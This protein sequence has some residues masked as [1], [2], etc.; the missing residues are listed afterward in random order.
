MDRLIESER[1]ILRTLKVEDAEK[2]FKWL[3]DPRVSKFMPY[4]TYE[5]VGE[6]EEWIRSNLNKEREFYFSISLKETGE[7][8]G[9]AS[10]EYIDDRELWSF[11]YNF[12]YNHWNKGYATEAGR[13]LIDYIK[14][15]FDG[16]K[17]GA[18][19]VVENIASEKAILKIGLKFSHYGTME[20]LDGSQVFKNKY[21][22][23]I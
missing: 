10:I 22:E 20:K 4:P 6:A 14:K 7:M 17:F 21:F 15:E 23:S 19:C 11:G 9:N 5:K 8:V 18:D 12:D 3:S 1:L 13:A 2:I 16:K